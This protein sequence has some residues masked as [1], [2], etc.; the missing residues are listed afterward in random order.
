M[1]RDCVCVKL[2]QRK[3][4]VTWWTAKEGFLN[5]LARSG[6]LLLISVSLSVLE[7]FRLL[8]VRQ[9]PSSLIR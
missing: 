9:R 7:Q 5:R 3:E 8:G 4:R 6:D 1:S 2:L